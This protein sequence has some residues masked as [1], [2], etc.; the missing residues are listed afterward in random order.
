MRLIALGDNCV[1]YYHNTGEAFPGGNAVNV[2]VHAA[3]QGAD[4][5]YLGAL[6]DDD[7]SEKIRHALL[8]NHVSFAHCPSKEGTTTKICSYDVVDGERSFVEVITGDHWAGPIVLNDAL[9]HYC[10][11]ADVIVSS[12]NAK[13]PEQLQSVEALP[14]VFAFDFGEKEKYRITEYY[15]KVCHT[16]DLALFS[17][18]EMSEKE[19]AAF[20]APLHDRGVVHVLATMGSQGQIVSNGK[21]IRKMSIHKIKAYDTMGAGDSF[22]AAFICE[23][24]GF[25]WQKGCVMPIDALEKAMLAGQRVSAE[26]CM[27]RGG[28][29]VE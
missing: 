15:D 25:G 1:D 10:A 24:M 19:F 12:C 14:A 29:H 5:E 7:M 9:L 20:A 6:A 18:K 21:Q 4:A 2:A 26:N 13:I 28:F 11:K 3:H 17:M 22:L 27:S 8:A 16:I 23:L